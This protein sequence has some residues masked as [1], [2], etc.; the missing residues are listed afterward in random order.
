LSEWDGEFTGQVGR[1]TQ[2]K[3]GAGG[4]KGVSLGVVI[5]ERDV[6]EAGLRILR[7]A[8]QSPAEKA[9]IRPG[10]RLTS[11]AGLPMTQLETLD[12]LLESLS[13]DDQVVIEFERNHKSEKALIRF[14][15]ASPQSA[16]D[17]A[18]NAD[19]TLAAPMP[20]H[21]SHETSG[22][23]HHAQ[24][25]GLLSVLE[26]TG[27]ANPAPV[28]SRAVDPLHRGLAPLTSR[29]MATPPTSRSAATTPGSPEE[30]ERLQSEIE[31][32]RE[33]IRQLQSQIDRAASD[34]DRDDDTGVEL[35][36]PDGN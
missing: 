15:G 35:L 32:Q 21:F 25:S 23:S 8:S 36:S 10:D 9:G 16:G 22:G 13:A 4:A 3:N 12:A 1:D 27:R 20:P 31:R 5:D 29:T 26:E 18:A 34:D 30:V 19:E 11:L 6:S 2:P 28:G 24:G 14:G 33:L 7:V 17:P